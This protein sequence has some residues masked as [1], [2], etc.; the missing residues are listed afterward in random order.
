MEKPLWGI[1]EEP[2][3]TLRSRP[4][5][6]LKVDRKGGALEV[7]LDGFVSAWKGSARDFFSA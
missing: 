2:N 4:L 1:S 6:D 5:V 7:V 3:K